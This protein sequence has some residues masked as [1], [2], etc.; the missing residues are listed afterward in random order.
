MKKILQ[1]K[2]TVKKIIRSIPGDAASG[3]RPRRVL[4][5]KKTV[6]SRRSVR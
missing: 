6:T 3:G 4:L 2:R 5:I 1:I